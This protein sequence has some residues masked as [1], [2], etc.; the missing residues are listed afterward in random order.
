[1]P[2]WTLA[3]ITSR[4]TAGLGNRSDIALSDASF[5]ANEAQREVWD[6]VP[7]DA[8]EVIA[9]S[10]TTSGEDKITLPTDFQELLHLSNLS[11]TPAASLQQIN[12][13]N[14]ESW[15]TDLGTPTHYL[16]YDSWLELRPSPNSAYSIQLRYRTQ[17][18]DMTTL[19]SVPS[20][21]TRFRRAVMIKTKELLAEHVISAPERAV[22]A[23]AEYVAYMS[24]TASDRALKQRENRFFSMSI[25]RARD[26]TPGTTTTNYDF[27]TSDY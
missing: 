5:W 12:L 17:L 15:A 18:S 13:E 10:S 26:R 19:T 27:D 9:V 1:M 24:K 2:S 16:L 7:H 11:A 20:V 23:R 25:P 22:A 14:A 21:A 8:Q 6:D 4:A 3:D